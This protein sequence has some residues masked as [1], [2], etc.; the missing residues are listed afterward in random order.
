MARLRLIFDD[1]DTVELPK[2]SLPSGKTQTKRL[3]VNSRQE[4][5]YVELFLDDGDTG[6]TL[7]WGV[8][9]AVLFGYEN[10]K[11]VDS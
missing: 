2:Y 9:G 5:E 1:G 3:R 6:D 7:D 11:D 10:K 8:R 4:S